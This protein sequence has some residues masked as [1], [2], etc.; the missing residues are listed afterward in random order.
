MSS[1]TIVTLPFQDQFRGHPFANLFCERP[2][3]NIALDPSHQ[4]LARGIFPFSI[5]FYAPSF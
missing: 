2:S 5:I 1:S 3:T 4:Q